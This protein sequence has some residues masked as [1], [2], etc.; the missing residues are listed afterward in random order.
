MHEKTETGNI[1]GFP[2]ELEVLADWLECLLTEVLESP[3][4]ELPL[5]EP[6]SLENCLEEYVSATCKKSK[7]PI[8]PHATRYTEV[9]RWAT[10]SQLHEKSMAAWR[11]CN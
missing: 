1:L 2:T 6:G 11:G 3:L 9:S 8:V 5:A 10:T 7:C 4:V